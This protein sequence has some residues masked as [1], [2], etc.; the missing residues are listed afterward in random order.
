MRQLFFRNRFST[1]IITVLK[2]G[3]FFDTLPYRVKNYA[4]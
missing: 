4:R 2:N 1:L 3:R